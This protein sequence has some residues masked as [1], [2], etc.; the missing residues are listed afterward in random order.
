MQK[1]IKNLR[2]KFPTRKFKNK[3]KTKLGETWE[4]PEW[5]KVGEKLYFLF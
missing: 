5:R 1:I 2:S 3:K 4:I